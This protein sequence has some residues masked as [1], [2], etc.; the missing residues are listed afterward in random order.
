M[1]D[2]ASIPPEAITPLRDNDVLFGRGKGPQYHPGNVAFRT[3]VDSRKAEYWSEDQ[4]YGEKMQ[5]AG[6]VYD[7]IVTPT[8][9]SGQLGGRFLKQTDD[10]DAVRAEIHAGRSVTM[11][12]AK[13][14]VEVPRRLAVDKC[15]MALRQKGSAAEQR[16]ARRRKRLSLPGG[17]S[18]GSYQNAA[19]AASTVGHN[20]DYGRPEQ[21]SSAMM[22][23]M[24]SFP[25]AVMMG[26]MSSFPTVHVSSSLPAP[27]VSTAGSAAAAVAAA[28]APSSL[29]LDSLQLD[30]DLQLP[31]HGPSQQQHPVQHIND[32]LVAAALEAAAEAFAAAPQASAAAHPETIASNPQGLSS[33]LLNANEYND[34]GASNL[35]NFPPQS[36]EP[37][38][39][40][41]VHHLEDSIGS[42]RTTTAWDDSQELSL[43]S[44]SQRQRD[45]T[46]LIETSLV[47]IQTYRS[48]LE[49]TAGFDANALGRILY[50]VFIDACE[51]SGTTHPNMDRRNEQ[52]TSATGSNAVGGENAEP[53]KRERRNT[54]SHQS[55]VSLGY[56][57]PL[58]NLLGCLL[59]QTPSEAIYSSSVEV[60]SDLRELL[61]GQGSDG[62][63][64]Q[65]HED[66]GQLHFVE[67]RIFG[68]DE[69]LQ[70]LLSA[71]DR[72]VRDGNERRSFVTISGYSGTGKTSMVNQLGGRL[73]ADKAS[74]VR[75][76]FSAQGQSMSALFQAFDDYCRN[77]SGGDGRDSFDS[78]RRDVGEVL[79]DRSGILSGCLPSL[80]SLLGEKTD[81]PTTRAETKEEEMNQILFYFIKFVRAISGPDHPVVIVL[82]D[83]QWCDESCLE[84]VRMLLRDT[85]ITSALFIG[86]YR[87][88]VVGNDHRFSNLFG[89]LA[90]EASLPMSSIS[91]KNLDSDGVN[92]LISSVLRLNPRYTRPLAEVLQRKTQGNPM[93]VRQL[94]RSM[95]DD[96]LL[97]FSVIDRR[98]QWNIEAISSTPIANNTVSLVLSMMRTYDRGVQNVLRLSALLGTTFK[99]E[100]LER[101]FLLYEYGMLSP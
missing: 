100:I 88:E 70:V 69:E 97:T 72:V 71:Y 62:E 33:G 1:T 84:V 56:P 99:Q 47:S 87:D 48:A 94:L 67:N 19:A 90:M 30:A 46:S 40:E 61:Q 58:S 4:A 60:E 15:K 41:H 82:D 28:T 51:D 8:A 86:C 43:G 80:R 36:F 73:L 21:I 65:A 83:I 93:F 95:V 37:F 53:A 77:V 38:P 34:G 26:G 23:G 101:L 17:A 68:R 91:L 98:W 63:E 54:G 64:E 39:F 29:D 59:N 52:T 50:Q 24:S 35:H 45:M 25:E 81:A 44:Q 3:L 2:Q 76:S 92:A 66:D 12:G 75:C 10:M 32:V 22:G 11:Y 5:L 78:I 55:L 18:V 85:E 16:E 13:Y 79:R 9:S 49:A 14:Y 42:T 74:L 20:I 7:T 57:V 27:S 96:G 89:E 31:L 6:E